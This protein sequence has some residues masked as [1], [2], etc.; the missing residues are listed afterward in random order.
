MNFGGVHPSAE[1]WLNG[2]RLGKN[3]APFVP[4]G[5]D[6]TGA[7]SAD[8]ENLLV[9]RVYE[10]N[11]ILGLAYNWQGN[12]SGLYRGVE[13]TATG[14]TYLERVW[15]HPDVDGES[16]RLRIRIG[17]L[18]PSKGLAVLHVTAQ[19]MGREAAPVT[20]ENLITRMDSTFELAVPSPFPWSPDSPALYRVDTV[21]SS[22]GR[23]MDCLSE[24]V[25]FVKLS[26]EGKH[27]C[28]NNEP[29]YMRG[30]CDHHSS[31]LTGCPDWDRDRW[32]RNLSTLREYGYNWVRL[33]CAQSPEYFYAADEVGM[34]GEATAHFMSTSGRSQ[35][36]ICGRL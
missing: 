18:D 31:P 9:V 32:R 30:S 3:Q 28:I 35:S 21:L 12:W 13:L 6:I 5:F 17:R 8:T 24:R 20:A 23:I 10:K 29:Y 34:L 22:G 11:R 15:V 2:I 25:G 19:P 33:M 7:V 4:F 36:P 26:T 27:F 1:V 14:P 16:M